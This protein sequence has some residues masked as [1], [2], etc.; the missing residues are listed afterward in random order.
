M[1]YDINGPINYFKLEHNKKIIY[2]FIDTWDN[3][4]TDCSLIS[5]PLNK[6]IDI[7]KFLI[8][9][10]KNTD[11]NIDF[12]YS[13]SYK[14]KGKYEKNKR[15]IYINQ[16][17]KLPNKINK[18]N[19]NFI[20]NKLKNKYITKIIN[21]VYK[22]DL[23]MTVYSY[24]INKIIFDMKK[25]LKYIK[26]ILKIELK[27]TFNF[28]IKKN[29]INIQKNVLKLI[30]L[31]KLN[32]QHLI[33]T[34]NNDN[35]FFDLQTK[36]YNLLYVITNSINLIIIIIY[37]SFDINLINKNNNKTIVYFPYL[38]GLNLIHILVK[39]FDF[40]IT[41]IFFLDSFIDKEVNK[42][43]K[44][45]DMNYESL[46]FMEKIFINNNKNNNIIQCINS[47]NLDTILS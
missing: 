16:V 6:S 8:N 15:D 44:N 32:K 12:F 45:L 9:F 41:D 20:Y 5:N 47:V 28:N 23:F 37:T 7:D 1:N 31:L 22:Y 42:I 36:I 39:F 18:K 33:Y 27:L 35:K 21:I 29:F 30:N 34:S 10:L 40:K 14:I 17:N 11:E 38:I 25:V 26:K 13:A 3:N 46:L 19:I 24:E 4:I 43:I 2:I